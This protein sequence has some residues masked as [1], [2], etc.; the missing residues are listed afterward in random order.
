VTL[1]AL[2]A[3]LSAASPGVPPP[4]ARYEFLSGGRVTGGLVRTERPDRSVEVDFAFVENGRGPKVVETIRFDGAGRVAAHEVVGTATFGARVDERFA[5]DG[6]RASWKTTA[7][8][9]STEIDG[10]AVYVPLAPTPESAAVA[11]R[12]AL[13]G[14]GRVALLPAGELTAERVRTLEVRGV[15]GPRKIALYVLRGVDYAPAYV[16]LDARGQLFAWLEATTPP[17]GV[18][19]EGYRDEAPRLVE[20]HKQADAAE[21]EKLAAKARHRL[22]VPLAIRDVRVFDPVAGAL[23]PP[24]TVYVFR[25]KVSAVF[26]ASEP[27]PADA[28]VVD[29]GGR[30]LLPALVDMHGHESPWSSALQIAGGVTTVRDVGSSEREILELE[31]KA[32]SGAWLGPRLWRACFL[33]GES[34][35]AARFTGTVAASLDEALAWVDRHAQ[36]GCRGLKLYNSIRPEWMAPLA[37]RARARGLRVSGHVPAFTRARNA[38]EAGYQEIHHVN[39]LLLNF[40]MKDGEDTRTLARFTAVAERAKDLD[41]DG[42]EFQAFVA[43]LKEKDAAHDPTLAAFEDMFVQAPGELS[44]VFGPIADHLPSA[45][46]RSLRQTEM[47]ADAPTRERYRASFRKALEAVARLDR[48][49]VTLVPGTDSTAGFALHHELELWVQAGIPPARVLQHATLGVARVL[50]LDREIGRV[51][52]GFSADVVLVDG[53]PTRDISAIRRIAMVVKR[54]EVFFPAEIYP[55]LGVKPFVEAPALRLPAQ[56]TKTA[57]VAR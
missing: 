7:D 26:P 54:G 17:F 21:L 55:V 2:L 44:R 5:R 22:E 34:P 37:E 11:V 49:G 47:E 25:G 35:F 39:Q 24:S 16:W 36:R 4:A 56:G 45:V 10:P 50:G 23:G 14:H 15:R 32:E 38:V 43:L 57:A 40:V 8:E 46:R 42:P 31:A 48:A 12:A 51:A 33:E 9:G 19:A 6:R 1:A 3:V 20:A 52:P 30:T 29:G 28:A 41:L 13:A 27:V 18:I 53:D